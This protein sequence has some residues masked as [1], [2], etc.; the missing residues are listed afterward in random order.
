MSELKLTN[1]IITQLE[2]NQEYME[3]KV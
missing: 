1:D 2:C 3:E